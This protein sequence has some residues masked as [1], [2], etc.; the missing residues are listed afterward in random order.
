M[1]DALLGFE[2]VALLMALMG[3]EQLVAML[4]VGSVAVVVSLVFDQAV[5]QEDRTFYSMDSKRA[6]MMIQEVVSCEVIA[7]ASTVFH[8]LPK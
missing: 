7:V 8:V 4:L 3:V 2:V 5:N 6:K 1:R